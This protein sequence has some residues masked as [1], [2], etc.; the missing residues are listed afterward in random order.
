MTST[1]QEMKAEIEKEESVLQLE[2]WPPV[3]RMHIAIAALSI[4]YGQSF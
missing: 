4:Q 1:K 3:V 2:N